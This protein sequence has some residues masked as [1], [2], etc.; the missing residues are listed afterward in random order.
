MIAAGSLCGCA[1]DVPFPDADTNPDAEVV[2][3]WVQSSGGP[4]LSLARGGSLSGFDGCNTMDGRWE[5]VDSVVTFS[6]LA[7]TLMACDG[8]DTWLARISTAASDEGSL[9]L[10][11]ADGRRIGMLD[12]EGRT[13]S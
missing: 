4:Y 5:V 8:V 3:S 10:F 13:P 11:D 2:G 7:A 9:V 6:E 1:P 12:R